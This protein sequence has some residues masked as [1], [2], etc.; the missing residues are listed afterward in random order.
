MLS[1]RD[2]R[3]GPS[4]CRDSSGPRLKRVV[5]GG[6]STQI[7][8]TGGIVITGYADLDCAIAAMRAG[9]LDLLQKPT[10]KEEVVLADG[11]VIVPDLLVLETRPQAEIAEL[12]D[13]GFRD[14]AASPARTSDALVHIDKRADG[15]TPSHATRS[16]FPRTTAAEDAT[17]STSA[18]NSTG[19]WPKITRS[20]RLLARRSLEAFAGAQLAV[21]WERSNENRCRFAGR[22]SPSGWSR[23]G[24]TSHAVRWKVWPSKTI[25][26]AR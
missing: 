25:A 8:G 12:L 13:G 4:R 10:S 21:E 7:S 5:I 18:R 22:T 20:L 26:T 2:I 6:V 19:R 15:S 14:V 16:G 11:D 1:L 24:Q 3:D 23:R 9:A 17:A